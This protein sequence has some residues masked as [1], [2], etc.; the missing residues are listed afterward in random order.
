[1]SGQT[2]LRK[3]KDNS[4]NGKKIVA[5]QFSDKGLVSIIYKELLQLN[6]KKVTQFI[7][8][9]RIWISISPKKIHSGKKH[10]KK[11]S[12]SSAT[13]ENAG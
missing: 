5:S 12:V 6:N 3:Q 9:H 1:M 7:N 11:A 13:G 4:Q 10:K 8:G 2:L